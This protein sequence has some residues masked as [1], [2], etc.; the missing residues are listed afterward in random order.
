MSTA[1]AVRG[2]Y[3]APADAASASGGMSGELE[4]LDDADGTATHNAADVGSAAW[5]RVCQL[6]ASALPPWDEAGCHV[7]EY[8]EVDGEA[9]YVR[10]DIDAMVQACGHYCLVCC[11]G[12]QGDIQDH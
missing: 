7:D 4:V 10:G 5:R 8:A 2:R 6:R 1:D 3:Q 12:L 11:L 9:W